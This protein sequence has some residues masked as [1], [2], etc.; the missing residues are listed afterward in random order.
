MALSWSCFGL[1][2]R[3]VY[4]QNN[5]QLSVKIC[6]NFFI[7]ILVNFIAYNQAYRFTHFSQIE[8]EKTKRPEELSIIEKLNILFL[9][10][11]IPKPKNTTTPTRIYDTVQ[12]Q[13]Y[14][15]LEAWY[16]KIP[17]EKGTIILFHGYSSSKSGVL[18]YSEAFNEKEEEYHQSI[19]QSKLYIQKLEEQNAQLDR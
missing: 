11:N 4:K 15:T 6:E 3:S 12:F 13:S 10:I 1:F 18:P 8:Q 14:E 2:I 19:T 17:D 9:G 7:F 16:V 5:W